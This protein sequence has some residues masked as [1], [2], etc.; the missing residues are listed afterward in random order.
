MTSLEQLTQ[1]TVSELDIV[2]N[3]ERIIKDSILFFIRI[4]SFLFFYT[5]KQNL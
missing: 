3:S 5:D 1:N 4:S 2:E